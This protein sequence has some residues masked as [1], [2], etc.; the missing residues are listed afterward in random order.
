MFSTADNGLCPIDEGSPSSHHFLPPRL[1]VSARDLF[2]RFLCPQTLPVC[3]F[4][5]W[6]KCEKKSG[7]GCH[8]RS[9]KRKV[10][11]AAHRFYYTAFGIENE[12]SPSF[13]IS[14][15]QVNYSPEN[16]FSPIYCIQSLIR[17]IFYSSNELNFRVDGFSGIDRFFAIHWNINR[18][19]NRK[20]RT[21][22][23]DFI[24]PFFT[25]MVHPLGGCSDDGFLFLFTSAGG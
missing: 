11:G 21:C 5:E 15:Q 20:Q 24:S 1:C 10:F 7:S 16:H 3:F 9:C 2:F 17:P 12:A 19:V 8:Y 25:K 23:G 14:N 13:N 18:P 22:R 4:R 6:W